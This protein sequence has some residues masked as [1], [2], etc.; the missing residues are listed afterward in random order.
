M[1]DPRLQQHFIDAADLLYQ[2]ADGL[3]PALEAAVAALVAGLTGG[4]KV[5]VAADATCRPLAAHAAALLVGGFERARPELAAL[6]LPETPAPASQVRALGQPGDVLLLLTAA[7]LVEDGLVAAV[8]AAQEREM[9]VVWLGG[10]AAGADETAALLRET[11]VALRV[12]HARR[13]RV[14]ETHALA[15]H[16]LC[17]GVD[18]Q[19]LGEQENP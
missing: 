3:G 10:G 7:P 2:A 5:L 12:P 17:D 8:R 6:A 4:G 18:I 14:F 16:A 11:D 15:L 9:T 1:S 13:A 19:L